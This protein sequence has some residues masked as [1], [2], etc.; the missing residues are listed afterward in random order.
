M[1]P[2]EGLHIRTS[3]HSYADTVE[4]TRAVLRQ[5][6][7]TIFAEIDQAGAARSVGLPL[8]P[9]TLFIFGN[10]QAGTALMQAVP[11]F[12]LELPL[13]ILVWRDD[14]GSTKVAYRTLASLRDAYAASGVEDRADH[15][16]AAVAKLIEK[17]VTP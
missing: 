14:D 5:V 12:A 2:N 1:R 13:K 9:T 4:A 15:I 7:Q 8:R 3:V 17:I 11:L 16:D 6:G 10:P